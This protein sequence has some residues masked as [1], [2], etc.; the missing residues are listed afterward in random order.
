MSGG[1]SLCTFL[2]PT[3]LVAVRP[4]GLMKLIVYVHC[5]SCDGTWCG[6]GGPVSTSCLLFLSKRDELGGGHLN[7]IQIVLINLI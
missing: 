1:G 7:C 6:E 5:K 2:T 4:I 3:T